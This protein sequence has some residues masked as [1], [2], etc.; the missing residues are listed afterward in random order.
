MRMTEGDI[1]AGDLLAQHKRHLH[2]G[3]SRPSEVR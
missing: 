3:G 1:D 2:P